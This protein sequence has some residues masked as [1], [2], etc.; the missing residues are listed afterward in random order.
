MLVSTIFLRGGSS[1]TV[2]LPVGTYMIK[3]AYG[4]NWFGTDE[5]F[6]DENA[7][8]VTLFLEGG[9]THDFRRNF[10]YTLTLRDSDIS[11]TIGAWLNEGR[12]GF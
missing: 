6:G 11:D 10:I 3:T 7:V 1:H 5:Y 12:D 4:D 9:I 8:Y 2:R